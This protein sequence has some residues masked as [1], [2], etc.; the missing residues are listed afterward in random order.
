MGL[1]RFSV[2][3]NSVKFSLVW[4]G[5]VLVFGV[6]RKGIIML[7]LDWLEQFSD[8]LLDYCNDSWM[9]YYM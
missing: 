9:N 7:D 8:H 2:K 5:L 4:F 3:F 1:I 6:S